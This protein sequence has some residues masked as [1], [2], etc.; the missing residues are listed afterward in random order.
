MLAPAGLAIPAHA[1]PIAAPSTIAALLQQ[2]QLRAHSAAARAVAIETAQTAGSDGQFIP[3][4]GCH[5]P[6]YPVP[7]HTDCPTPQGA[8]AAERFAEDADKATTPAAAAKSAAA[9]ASAVIEALG[10]WKPGTDLGP[11]VRAAAATA[12]K[13]ATGGD[14]QLSNAAT[15]A[16]NTAA[17]TSLQTLGAPAIGKIATVSL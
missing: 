6:G 3:A 10:T 14:V 16:E 11:S 12:A 5:R 9:A 2:A 7:P 4:S 15:T 13:A 17:R 1:A 8:A